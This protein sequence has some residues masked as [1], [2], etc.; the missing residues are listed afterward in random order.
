MAARKHWSGGLDPKEIQWLSRVV[1]QPS[2]VVQN[3][4]AVALKDS[5]QQK[6]SVVLPLA[7]GEKKLVLKKAATAHLD[8]P[9][10]RARTGRSLAAEHAFYTLAAAKANATANANV[11]GSGNGS[12]DSSL[13]L[14][15][16]VHGAFLKGGEA[17]WVGIERLERSQV[18]GNECEIESELLLLVDDARTIALPGAKMEQVGPS[19]GGLNHEEAIAA[20]RWL[21]HLHATFMCKLSGSGGSETLDQSK[22]DVWHEGGYWSYSKRV[23]VVHENGMKQPADKIPGNIRSEWKLL[24]DRLGKAAPELKDLGL[25]TGR[26]TSSQS[27]LPFS[28]A[29]S[30]SAC[31]LGRRLSQGSSQLH[32]LCTLLHGDFKG[33]NIFIQQGDSEDRKMATAVD[34]QWSGWG[35]GAVDLVYFLTTSLSAG[36]LDQVDSLI[37]VYHKRLLELA[38]DQDLVSEVEL[39]HYV[40]L[41][42]ADYARYLVAEMWNKVD[43]ASIEANKLASNVG[44]HKRSITH[45]VK[46][47]ELATK[48]LENLYKSGLLSDCNS[49]LSAPAQYGIQ[50]RDFS[51]GDDWLSMEEHR[52]YV[53]RLM[54]CCVQLSIMSGELIRRIVDSES[55]FVTNKDS[56]GG[57]DPQTLADVRAE[58][59][60]VG[61]LSELFPEVVLVGEEGMKAS[62][63][64]EEELQKEIN[65]ACRELESSHMESIAQWEICIPKGVAFNLKDLTVFIDPLDGTKELLAGNRHAVTTL[66]GICVSGKPILGT[67]HQ[68]LTEDRRTVWGGVG[69]SGVFSHQ[70]NEVMG[71]ARPIAPPCQPSRK[72]IVVTTRSHGNERVKEAISKLGD[73]E[74]LA[75]GGAGCKMLMLIDG[76]ADA[77]VFPC[78]GTKRWDTCAGDALIQA[79]GGFLF[80]ADSGLPYEYSPKGNIHNCHG[81]IASIHKYEL[82]KGLWT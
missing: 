62:S 12:T 13:L 32:H 46:V 5:V 45:L 54:G 53:A 60:I 72:P 81:V 3:A 78:N 39:R 4:V 51:Q 18:L 7:L 15:P 79:L 28:V 31:A 56:E 22:V 24:L 42:M 76:E 35:V 14:L 80:K 59:F 52:R 10:R 74:S 66:L 40:D 38:K 49:F 26:G 61:V 33:A 8:T 23:V 41:A 69:I 75:V 34:F 63:T 73:V 16:K 2:A 68:P 64:I 82:C 65:D 43:M 27:P 48:S 71:Q 17:T 9:E 70:K 30:E 1:S 47:T 55:L 57:F 44:M 58:R 25:V 77:W 37:K 50:E 67:I 19:P 21:A 6:A 29:L 20:V 11:S 36:C